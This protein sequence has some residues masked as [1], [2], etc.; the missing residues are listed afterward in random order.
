MV[1]RLAAMAGFAGVLVSTLCL[2]TSSHAGDFRHDGHRGHHGGHHQGYNQGIV[3]GDGLPSVVPRVGTF[4]GSIN[5]VRVPKVGI[6]MSASGLG[7]GR[8]SVVVPRHRTPKATIIDV[9]VET[10]DSACSYEAGVCVIR[11]RR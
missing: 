11:L 2:A 4:A 3:G 9:N 8:S 7:S 5:A 1:S 6:Y 10:A